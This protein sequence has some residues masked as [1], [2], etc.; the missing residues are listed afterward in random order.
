MMSIS[1]TTVDTVMEQEGLTQVDVIKMDIQGAEL[2]A[3]GGMRR[4]LDAGKP[5]RI[6]VE[7]WP[8][9]LSKSGGAGEDFFASFQRLGSV[10]FA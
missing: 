9:G 3:F 6:F 4:L 2:L 10:Y 8:Y 5:L 1:L 7:Y